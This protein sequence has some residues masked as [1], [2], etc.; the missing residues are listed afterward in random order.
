MR[1]TLDQWLFKQVDNSALVAFRI[2]FGLLLACEAFGSIATGM[3]RRQFVEPKFTFTFIG[4][5]FLEPLPG[6]WMYIFYCIMGV[7][8]LMVMVGYKYR[9][10]ITYYAITWT[11]VYLLQKSSYNLHIKRNI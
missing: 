2:I 3:V 9:I 7:A 11:Y 8:G 10:A 5:D 1:V 6:N 4:F